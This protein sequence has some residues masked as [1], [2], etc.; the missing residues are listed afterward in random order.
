MAVGF[1]TGPNTGGGRQGAPARGGVSG[2]EM[3][4]GIGAAQQRNDAS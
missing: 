3:G 1:G 2:S 4:M